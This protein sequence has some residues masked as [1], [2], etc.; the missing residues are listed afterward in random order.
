MRLL[1]SISGC[2][3]SALLRPPTPELHS[4][5]RARASQQGEQG[6]NPGRVTPDIRKWESCWRMPFEKTY[7]SPSRTLPL[8]G[9]LLPCNGEA[10][11]A[12]RNRLTAPPAKNLYG[13]CRTQPG[14]RRRSTSPFFL[15]LLSPPSLHRGRD[16]PT[17]W[18][19]VTVQGRGRR[20]PGKV[21]AQLFETSTRPMPA[22]RRHRIANRQG[23]RKDPEK[24]C[25]PA[26]LLGTIP[27]CENA[28]ATQP[29]IEP[30]S[31][32]RLE[33]IGLSTTPQRQKYPCD[34]SLSHH[35]VCSDTSADAFHSVENTRGRGQ[36]PKINSLGFRRST[37]QYRRAFE[38]RMSFLHRVYHAIFQEKADTDRF[39]VPCDGEE[40]E[41]L[42]RPDTPRHIGFKESSTWRRLG[43]PAPWE[44]THSDLPSSWNGA[45]AASCYTSGRIP[46]VT[47]WRSGPPRRNS[48]VQEDSG[49]RPAVFDRGRPAECARVKGSVDDDWRLRDDGGRGVVAGMDE[50]I[51]APSRT[52]SDADR[53]SLSCETGNVARRSPSHRNA[54][55]YC[56]TGLRALPMWTETSSRRQVRRHDLSF[57]PQPWRRRV[58]TGP[59]S[60]L[61][62][63][64]GG[65]WLG[66]LLAPELA[67]TQRLRDALLR[68]GLAPR[69]RPSYSLLCCQRSAYTSASPVMGSEMGFCPGPVVRTGANYVS[70]RTPYAY[71]GRKSCKETCVATED[72]AAMVSDWGYGYIPEAASRSER[73]E[74]AVFSAILE[75]CEMLF[76]TV[77]DV[78]T[79]LREL[80]SELRVPRAASRSERYEK[81][82]Y[83]PAAIH[84]RDG[85]RC[86]R[87]GGTCNPRS[88]P[89]L[90][91]NRGTDVMEYSDYC[92]RCA[93]VEFC[94]FHLPGLP[95]STVVFPCPGFDSRLGLRPPSPSTDAS[96]LGDDTFPPP[97][98]SGAAPCSPHFAL[99]GSQGRDVRSRSNLS[100]PLAPYGSNV[101]RNLV[102]GDIGSSRVYQLCHRPCSSLNRSPSRGHTVVHQDT[103]ELR[104]KYGTPKGT[105]AA[106]YRCG[107]RA[108]TQSGV[109]CRGAESRLEI[110][111]AKVN[112]GS[113][114]SEPSAR[115]RIINRLLLCSP[116]VDDLPI[117]NAVMYR[118]VS[119]VVWTNRTMVSS[120]TDTNRTGVLAV[121][122]IVSTSWLRFAQCDG[123]GPKL[124]NS[125]QI[126]NHSRRPSWYRR[127]MSTQDSCRTAE[128]VD[129]LGGQRLAGGGGRAPRRRERTDLV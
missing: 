105:E 8:A 85:A 123:I 97:L 87:E 35:A 23:E 127:P 76:L 54:S 82:A 63:G 15:F 110:T 126:E 44:V 52:A 125:C 41:E 19:A 61:M 96:F 50:R 99:I 100:I 81:A 107:E 2:V 94:V 116:L 37:S 79:P 57:T 53:S 47:D 75:C 58:Y 84:D 124:K 114:K 111:P 22:P 27:T 31:S 80:S 68:T 32:P 90:N 39:H 3:L 36:T 56:G 78:L 91:A 88:P 67:V 26:A 109:V 102:V 43:C 89:Q 17:L 83:S 10:S 62:E 60:I 95:L 45:L 69:R 25:R 120:N 119:S 103:A 30:G 71:I 86:D 55:L 51:A 14:H 101:P 113:R 112:S 106:R 108:G 121:V 42:L 49:W 48:R 13:Y 92:T 18:S 11:K 1:E 38:R 65:H 59:C 9:S 122:Y 21:D 104:G 28:G 7:N 77:P 98:H 128:D 70:E 24:T 115:G 117:M 64:E 16:P 73:Y 118:V 34:L 33:A 74:K 129:H 72:W 4:V 6:S 40:E 20:R 66:A 29:G 5:Q 46:T 12:L 93:L